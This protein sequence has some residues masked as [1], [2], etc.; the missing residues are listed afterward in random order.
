MEVWSGMGQGLGAGGSVGASHFHNLI[1]FFI[2][3]FVWLKKFSI[4]KLAS[5]ISVVLVVGWVM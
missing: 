5:L 2:N 3:H 4:P 1:V